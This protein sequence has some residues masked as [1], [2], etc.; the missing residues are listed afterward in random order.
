MTLYAQVL[1]YAQKMV[2]RSA[3]L[4]IR[5]LATSSTC[6]FSALSVLIEIPKKT[7]AYPIAVI[8][9]SDKTAAGLR[10]RW[11]RLYRYSCSAW[12]L[13]TLPS[14]FLYSYNVL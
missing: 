10:F 6:V 8:Y 14:M 4:N 13:C 2:M 12:V 7:N 5:F 3:P 1:N 9:I 11:S